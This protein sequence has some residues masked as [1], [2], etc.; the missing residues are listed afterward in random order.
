MEALVK[1]VLVVWWIHGIV[2]AKG[3]FLTLLSCIFPPFSWC[4][5]MFYLI[6]AS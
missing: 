5:S 6:G 2:V 4:V 3:F 1:L